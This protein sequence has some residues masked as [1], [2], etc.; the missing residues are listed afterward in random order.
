MLCF[1]SAQL[2]TLASAARKAPSWSSV[3]AHISNMAGMW[4][5]VPQ[6]IYHLAHWHRLASGWVDGAFVLGAL[7]KPS[8]AAPKW[9]GTCIRALQRFFSG[10]DRHNKGTV[11]VHILVDDMSAPDYVRNTLQAYVQDEKGC[12]RVSNL[13]L[14]AIAAIP[15]SPTVSTCSSASASAGGLGDQGVVGAD[16]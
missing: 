7:P 8:A 6:R 15:S 1:C 16:C 4:L 14:N 13:F 9:P 12:K 2:S 3:G 10:I 11:R 5:S